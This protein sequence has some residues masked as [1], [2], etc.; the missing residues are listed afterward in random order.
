MTRFRLL[1]HLAAWVPLAW[2]LW[3][4]WAGNLSVNP[5]QDLTQRT[6]FYALS[7]LTLSLAAT[8]LNTLLHFRQAIQVR[9]ALGLYAFMYA[10]IHVLIFLGLDY[11]FNL[12]FL[13]DVVLEKPYIWVGLS[14]FVILLSLAATSFRSSQKRLGKNWKRLHRLIYLA[15]PLVVVHFTWAVKGN[16]SSLQGDIVQPLSFGIAVGLLLLVRLPPVRRRLAQLWRPTPARRP[17]PA[18]Q[19]RSSQSYLKE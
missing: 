6:G 11:G 18:P 5:I 13:Q 4:W 10:V 2:L 8:P 19:Q 15:A 14:A 7:L 17:R 16:L 9:R 12:A 1:V 3:D